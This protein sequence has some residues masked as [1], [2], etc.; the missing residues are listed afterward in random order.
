MNPRTSE[1]ARST[2]R[3]ILGIRPGHVLG[4]ASALLAVGSVAAAGVLSGADDPDVRSAGVGDIAP[5]AEPIAMDAEALRPEV[6]QPAW[7]DAER[8]AVPGEAAEVAAVSASVE[9]YAARKEAEASRGAIWD[10][11]ADCESGDWDANGT[12]IPGSHR[13]DYGLTFSH[14]DIFEGGV[15]FHPGT[16]D[17]YRDPGMPGHAGQATRAQQIAVAEEVLADQG[18][19]AWPVCSR[20]L[21]YR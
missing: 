14:G 17:A 20:K 12:P 21:G 13:W 6:G 4:A 7:A 19:G 3:R 2:G 10:R 16:W 5:V 18:W 8:P 1:H 15:N 11:L 9:D